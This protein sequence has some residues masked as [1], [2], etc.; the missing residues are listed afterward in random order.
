MPFWPKGLQGKNPGKLCTQQSY[1][2][3]TF[4]SRV[5]NFDSHHQIFQKIAIII[6]C[7]TSKN[8]QLINEDCRI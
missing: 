1:K 7:N 4:A 3:T 8:Q 6:L 5:L 2:G